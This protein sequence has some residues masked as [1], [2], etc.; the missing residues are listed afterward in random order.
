MAKRKI[1]RKVES[2]IFNF[3]KAVINGLSSVIGY[4]IISVPAWLLI[5]ADKSVEELKYETG[6]DIKDTISKGIDYL[7]DDTGK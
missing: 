1:N 4:A 7:F 2:G 3:A 5:G 6:I